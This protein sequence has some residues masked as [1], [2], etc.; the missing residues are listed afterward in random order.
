MK[1]KRVLL[2]LLMCMTLVFTMTFTS[3][4]NP[5]SKVDIEDYID[6]YDYSKMETEPISVS[7]SD[8]DIETEIQSRLEE[9]KTVTDSKEGTVEDGDTINID[10]TGSI[11]GK[12][13]SGG[14]ETGR[15]LTIGSGT[16]IDG[17]ESGLIGAKVGTTKNI[18]VTFPDDYSDSDLA[19]K[20]AVFAVKINSKEVETIPELDEDF[21]KEHSDVDTVEE[22]KKEV[23]KELKEEKEAAALYDKKKEIWNTLISESTIKKDDDDKEKYPEEQLKEA[24]DQLKDLYENLAKDQNMS[25]SDYLEQLGMTEDTFNEQAEEYAKTQVKRDMIMYYIADKENI[26][27]S[28][29]DK[30]EYVKNLLALYGYTEETYKKA[31]NGKSYES[32]AGKDIIKAETLSDKV[33]DYILKL[34]IK[35]YEKSHEDSSDDK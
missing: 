31:N 21:V 23:K 6:I 15:D 33:G 24:E 30:K 2:S 17:F 5:Y 25:L 7:V 27:I 1:C 22:Y 14:E 35:N 12:K 10:Y 34:A 18:K 8:S 3:C 9:N 20:N 11:D 4:G 28:R 19:G 26:K 16:F 13:F 32:V 29:S